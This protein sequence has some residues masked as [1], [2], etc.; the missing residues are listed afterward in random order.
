MKNSA[1]KNKMTS[2]AELEKLLSPED[3]SAYINVFNNNAE[4]EANNTAFINQTLAYNAPEIRQENFFY[5]DE[6]TKRELLKELTALRK[7]YTYDKLD[8]EMNLNFDNLQKEIEKGEIDKSNGYIN[9]ILTEQPISWFRFSN[10]Y[11][12][13]EQHREYNL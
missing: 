12:T 3:Y 1:Y 13:L 11:P 8:W 10:P 9:I 6:T 2:L 5:L 7:T 4:P